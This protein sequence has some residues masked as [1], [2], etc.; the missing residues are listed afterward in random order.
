M[1][2]RRRTSTP[3]SRGAAS[4]RARRSHGG[5]TAPPKGPPRRRGPLSGR[6]PPPGGTL[7]SMALSSTSS[8][9]SNT[10]VIV[11]ATAMESGCHDT[12][13]S[14]AA[15]SR[16]LL[17]RTSRTANGGLQTLFVSSDDGGAVNAATRPEPTRATS[18]WTRDRESE[19]RGRGR[20]TLR[21]GLR[22]PGTL[23]A[24]GRF[25][26]LGSGL[27]LFAMHRPRAPFRAPGGHEC[28]AVRRQLRQPPVAAA[29]VVRV[30]EEG[31]LHQ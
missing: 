24:V 27:A 14:A 1:R 16:C 5:P 3:P 29:A 21:A 31:D 12:R 6:T 2:M 17:Y 7:R 11:P 9:I 4:R 23:L 20:I 10:R 18:D 19:S 22:T 15:D 26:A 13:L 28:L 25:P 30:A 8:S